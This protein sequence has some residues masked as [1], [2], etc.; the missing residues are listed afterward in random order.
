[1]LDGIRLALS[2]LTVLPVRAGR[3]DRT[4]AGRAMELAPLVGLVVALPAAGVLL[5]GRL[6]FDTG[7]LAAILAIATL[8][9][10]TRGL[11]L[12]GLA[13]LADGLGSHRD[14]EGTRHVMKDPAV[15]AFGVLWLFFVPLLQL[16]A[17][18]S[19]V[20]L[21]SGS[22]SLLLAVMT[23][24][25]AI[26]AACCSTPA[27]TPSGLGAMVAGTVRRAV[28]WLWLL[29]LTAAFA[30]Y[31]LVDPD[32]RGTESFR[33]ARTIAAPCLALL[34]A[35][36]VRRHAVRR[37]GGLTGDVLGALCELATTVCL[38]VLA[39]PGPHEGTP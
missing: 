2:T 7:L 31:A 19:C 24:R 38:V 3:T 10:V 32:T 34:V 39:V 35:Y 4:A 6:L 15:G 25:L 13:D 23:G 37:V 14:P 20:L 9:L 21:G 36:A 22:A 8:A 17:L 26:T 30:S 33:V 29:G 28:P 18:S 27:A 12:D 11:H 5:T 16:A 1:V